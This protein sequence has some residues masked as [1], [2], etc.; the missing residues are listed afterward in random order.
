MGPSSLAYSPIL[1]LGTLR[2]VSPP[3]ML[4]T[5]L[6]S[7]YTPT[8]HTRTGVPLFSQSQPA[9]MLRMNSG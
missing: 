9:V 8:P 1:Q 4:A 7:E 3:S 6:W 5:A 2:S